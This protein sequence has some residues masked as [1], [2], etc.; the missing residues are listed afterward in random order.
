[1][2]VLRCFISFFSLLNTVFL[3]SFS[4]VKQAHKGHGSESKSP[5]LHLIKSHLGVSL[6]HINKTKKPSFHLGLLME[7]NSLELSL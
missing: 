1:M 6:E 7:P 3:S 4:S 5:S 2:K